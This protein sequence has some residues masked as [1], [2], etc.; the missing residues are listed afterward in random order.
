MPFKELSIVSQREEFCRLA[1]SPGANVRD[2]CRRFGVGHTAAYKWLGRYRAGGA[3]ELVDRS[4][5]PLRSPSRTPEELEAWVL[6]LRAEHP[7]WGGRKLRR[8]LEW[9]GL[10][11]PPS[12]STITE[13][14]RRNGQ[15][16]P[17]SGQA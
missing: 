11:P 12:A 4:R 5:R 14:L 16:G 15:D 9:A 13:I 7:C 17:R 1:C 6:A 8:L 3:L 2:L 10:E